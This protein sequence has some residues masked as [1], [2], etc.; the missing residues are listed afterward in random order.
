MPMPLV[1]CSFF[2][3]LRD[4]TVEH[5][6]LAFTDHLELIFLYNIW[7]SWGLP[8][9]AVAFFVMR[10]SSLTCPAPLLRQLQHL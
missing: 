5:F 9:I 3:L 6:I 8:S 1:S 7:D 2:N 4:K 10:W